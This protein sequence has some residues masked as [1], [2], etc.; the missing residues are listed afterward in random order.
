MLDTHGLPENSVV[1]S[2]G[3]AGD[4]M[5]RIFAVRAASEDLDTALREDAGTDELRTLVTELVARAREAER[6]R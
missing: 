5:D 1:L 6:L 2:G 3:E 4:L